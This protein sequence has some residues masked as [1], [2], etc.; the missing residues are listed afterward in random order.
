MSAPRPRQQQT[1][2]HGDQRGR[3]LCFC[4]WRESFL[5]SGCVASEGTRALLRR[6]HPTHAPADDARPELLFVD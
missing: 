2:T 4:P 5:G 1:P 6:D 3:L